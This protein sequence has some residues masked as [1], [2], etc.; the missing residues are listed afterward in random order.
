MEVGEDGVGDSLA[1]L[2]K[3]GLAGCWS[4]FLNCLGWSGGTAARKVR[5]SPCAEAVRCRAYNVTVK[6]S[7]ARRDNIGGNQAI[8]LAGSSPSDCMT[9]IHNSSA[10]STRE[11]EQKPFQAGKGRFPN[12]KRLVLS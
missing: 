3:E 11:K 2:L 9:F 10:V 1:A 4:H 6:W 8:V 7:P 5:N 12:T